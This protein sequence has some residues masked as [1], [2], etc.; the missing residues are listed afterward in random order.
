MQFAQQ[1]IDGNAKDAGRQA[2]KCRRDLGEA[3]DAADIGDGDGGVPRGA[4]PA[5]RRASV[6]CGGLRGRQP[7]QLGHQRLEILLRALS[8]G[9]DERGGF[10]QRQIGEVRRIAAECCQQSRAMRGFG[11]RRS[12]VPSCVKRSISRSAA[13]G[14]AG[15]GQEA[16]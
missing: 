5:A 12:A 2:G 15:L 3:P 14:S 13:S 7:P 11:K 16:G 9:A 4:W 1:K 6:Q 8:D 10:E